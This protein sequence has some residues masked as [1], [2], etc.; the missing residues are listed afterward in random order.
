MDEYQQDVIKVL[1]PV[2]CKRK[3]NQE[4]KKGRGRGISECS[5]FMK[6]GKETEKETT[7]KP[8]TSF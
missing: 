7:E 2:N 8:L 1:T 6:K 5:S 4:I 3:N